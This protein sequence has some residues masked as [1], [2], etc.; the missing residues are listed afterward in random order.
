MKIL[1]VNAYRTN[2]L[3]SAEEQFSMFRQ[4][5]EQAFSDFTAVEFLVARHTEVKDYIYSQRKVSR[6][7]FRMVLI[8]RRSI[9]SIKIKRETYDFFLMISMRFQEKNELSPMAKHV[10]R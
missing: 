9:G 1:L 8:Q 6:P 2:H 5:V 7:L 3:G 10:A 4:V